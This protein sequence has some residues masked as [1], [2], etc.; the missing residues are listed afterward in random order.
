MQTRHARCCSRPPQRIHPPSAWQTA[1]AGYLIRSGVCWNEAG[2]QLCLSGDCLWFVPGPLG[3][4]LKILVW[5]FKSP[6]LPSPKLSI[7]FSWNCQKAPWAFRISWWACSAQPQNSA[8]VL[9]ESM[10]E[11]S[12]ISTKLLW[13]FYSPATAPAGTEA[14]VRSAL[15]IEKCPRFKSGD[16]T[17]AWLLETFPSPKSSSSSSCLSCSRLH[18]DMISIFIWLGGGGRLLCPTWRRSRQDWMFCFLFEIWER[19]LQLL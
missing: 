4:L 3:S 7:Y 11:A 1:V 8:S 18:S 12:Q 17:P 16:D 2:L 10:L 13:F 5:F 19:I 14:P 15:V 6:P 9:T